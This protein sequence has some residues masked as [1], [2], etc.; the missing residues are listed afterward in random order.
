MKQSFFVLAN[1]SDTKMISIRKSRYRSDKLTQTSDVGP[2]R[3]FGMSVNVE[4]LE[5]LKS[6]L[7]E[8][9]QRFNAGKRALEAILQE[10]NVTNRS[11]EALLQKRNTLQKWQGN[12]RVVTS[13]LTSKRSQLANLQ[14]ETVDL[15]AEERRVKAT[16][17]VRHFLFEYLTSFYVYLMKSALICFLNQ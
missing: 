1:V 4:A 13:R 3:F 8:L 6:S 17:T 7:V 15:C 14:K 5:L 12:R 9:E 2:S 11:R 10:E 16:C